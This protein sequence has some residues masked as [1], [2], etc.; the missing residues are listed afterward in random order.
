MQVTLTPQQYR[1]IVYEL[2]KAGHWYAAMAN[3][4]SD[5]TLGKT[6]VE[7][8]LANINSVLDHLARTLP[9]E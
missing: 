1:T 2:T 9:N 4:Y 7:I 3:R 6:K 5:P 8:Q